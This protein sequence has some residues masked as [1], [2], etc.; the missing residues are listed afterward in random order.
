MGENKLV[1]F[2]NDKALVYSF[3]VAVDFQGKPVNVYGVLN[4][5]EFK[6]GTYFVNFFDRQEI[7]G[8]S[9]ITLE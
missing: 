5:D 2:E 9:S 6:K 8:S 3:M 7:M 4:S 1:E